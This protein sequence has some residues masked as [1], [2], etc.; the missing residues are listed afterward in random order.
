MPKMGRNVHVLGFVLNIISKRCAITPRLRRSRNLHLAERRAFVWGRTVDEK[1]SSSPRP[2]QQQ[3]GSDNL[4][5]NEFRFPQCLPPHVMEVRNA[6]PQGRHGGELRTFGIAPPRPELQGGF[7]G[8]TTPSP[9]CEANGG[10]ASRCLVARGNAHSAV[11]WRPPWSPTRTAGPGRLGFR[12][13]SGDVVQTLAPVARRGLAAAGPG[14]AGLPV[15]LRK[16]IVDF[17]GHRSLLGTTSH[18][19]R[20]R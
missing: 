8:I 13:R 14:P 9:H 6:A 12:Y 11:R 4:W 17:V 2:R 3:P 16:M 20:S 5:I 15:G 18:H 1:R 10:T 7:N 19:S